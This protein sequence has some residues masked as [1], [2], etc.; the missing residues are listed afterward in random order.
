MLVEN[1]RAKRNGKPT[2]SQLELG[3]GSHNAAVAER[4][5]ALQLAGG[6]RR[7]LAVF[8]NL[9][10]YFISVLIVANLFG[11]GA[12]VGIGSLS[13]CLLTQWFL[14]ARY[15]Q[16]LGKKLFGIRVVDANTLNNLPFG[17]YLLRELIDGLIYLIFSVGALLS[18]L[19]ATRRGYI[20]TRGSGITN[21]LLIRG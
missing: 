17:R 10:F 14:M 12:H 3:S 1:P 11:E 9:L 18:F 8:V 19:L 7:F 21:S 20:E 13:F 15:S 5:E 2:A 4:T 16:T 6:F